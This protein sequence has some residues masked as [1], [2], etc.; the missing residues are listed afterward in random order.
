MLNEWVTSK[1]EK[2]KNK[3]FQT[4]PYKNIMSSKRLKFIAHRFESDT[5][6][7]NGKLVKWLRRKY[8]KFVQ[9]SLQCKILSLI[10]NDNVPDGWKFGKVQ[11][12]RVLKHIE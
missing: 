7:Q 10:Y 12:N 5:F 1:S 3:P 4:L 2:F 9:Q 6:R 11:R 8:H